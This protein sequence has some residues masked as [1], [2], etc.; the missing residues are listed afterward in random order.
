[1]LVNLGPMLYQ[2]KKKHKKKHDEKGYLGS[3]KW[4]FS[5]KREGFLK[6]DK[7]ETA[8]IRGKI[9][10]ENIMKVRTFC[11]EHSEKDTCFFLYFEHTV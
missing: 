1:M 4:H 11:G 9:Q 3:E 6:S 7:K 5:G 2:K 10:T 8:V